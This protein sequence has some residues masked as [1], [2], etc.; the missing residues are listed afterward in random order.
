[1]GEKEMTYPRHTLL[2]ITY[3]GRLRLL[4]EKAGAGMDKHILGQMLAPEE[5]PMTDASFWP[6]DGVRPP[7]PGIVR[8]ETAPMEEGELSVGFVSWS[9]GVGGRLRLPARIVQSEVAAA[10]SPTEVL[11]AARREP[12]RFTRTPAL[13]ALWRLDE[14][15]RL[16]G[17][18]LGVWGSAGME[19]YTGYR[20]THPGSDLDVL[21]EVED[22]HPG[23][24][25]LAQCMYIVEEIE[26]EFAM[27]IDPELSL[28]NGYGVSLKELVNAG[29][30]TVLGKGLRD[31][32][33][34]Q[35]EAIL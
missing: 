1:M 2:D 34:L 31:V 18:K 6:G 29:S 11:D 32:V 4:S 35:K 15:L 7:V 28:R 16:P 10:H 5:Y 25:T 13:R 24:D 17:V 21:L 14:A 26:R 9:C 19:L 30:A 22:G 3:E 12:E 33:L 23:R 27:R 20:F 8:R